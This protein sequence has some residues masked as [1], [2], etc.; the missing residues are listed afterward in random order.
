MKTLAYLLAASLA[1]IGGFDIPEARQGVGV[2]AR[3]FY[4]VDDYAIAKYDKKT[5][6]S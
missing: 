1:Q 4:A 6:S 5:G 3:H 2:D